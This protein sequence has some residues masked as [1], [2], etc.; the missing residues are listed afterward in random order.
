MI[1]AVRVTSHFIGLLPATNLPE[2][3]EGRESYL[4]PYDIHGDVSKVE[5]KV[6]LRAFT[7]EE[8]N[9]RATVLKAAAKAAQDAFPGATVTVDVK[10][11]YRNMGMMLAERPEVMANLEKAVRLQGIDPVRKAIRGGTDGARLSFMGLPTP[12]V[13]AGGQNFHSLQEWAS[14]DWMV[15]ASETCVR[16]AGVWAGNE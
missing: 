1:N 9:D 2:T 14:L 6:L 4:H 13:W 7:V 10:E 8:L 12:N 11:Q 3:T 5:L 16:I 15:A